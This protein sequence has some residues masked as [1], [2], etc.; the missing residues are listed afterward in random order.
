MK[1]GDVGVR[2]R[3]EVVANIVAHSISTISN[4][5]NVITKAVSTNSVT[6]THLYVTL[7][8]VDDRQGVSHRLPVVLVID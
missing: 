6:A 8:K 3:V 1:N 5:M 7:V 2:V 4:L